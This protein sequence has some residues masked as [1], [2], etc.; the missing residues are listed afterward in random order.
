MPGETILK[1]DLAGDGVHITY[2]QTT[3]DDDGPTQ[4]QLLTY[5]G[6][7]GPQRTWSGNALGFQGS[8]L[9]TLLTV[10]MQIIQATGEVITLTLI[11][12]DVGSN[13]DLSE[14]PIQ[15]LAIRKTRID[16]TRPGGHVQVNYQCYRLEGMRKISVQP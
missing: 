12:P 13:I 15:T 1:Y 16:P 2:T 8:Q 3:S 4:S 7:D 11:L 6:P 9:G 14:L 5:Q 10:T